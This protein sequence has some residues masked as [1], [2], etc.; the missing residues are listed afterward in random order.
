MDRPRLIRIRERPL[1]P[2]VDDRVESTR[3]TAGAPH[4]PVLGEKAATER[5]PAATAADDQR[6]SQ[7]SLPPD[8][9][10]R[11]SCALAVGRSPSRE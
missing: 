5:T 7:V 9:Q 10:R 3:L 1:E 2:R 8:A 4:G 6:P 11:R